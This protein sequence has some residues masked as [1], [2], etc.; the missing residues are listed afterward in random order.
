MLSNKFGHRQEIV[1]IFFSTLT[2]L[3]WTFNRSVLSTTTEIETE[4]GTNN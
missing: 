3:S 4:T 1:Y 2:V